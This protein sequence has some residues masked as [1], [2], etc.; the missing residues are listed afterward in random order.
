MARVAEVALKNKTCPHKRK[1]DLK[2]NGQT[3]RY[4]NRL[5]KYILSG[6]VIEI[7]T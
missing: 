5:L 3:E 4:L 7:D 2:H 1:G 6:H